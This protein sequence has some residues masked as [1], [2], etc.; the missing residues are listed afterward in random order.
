MKKK[1]VAYIISIVVLASFTA[2]FGSKEAV[3]NSSS[4]REII[5]YN[6]N[7]NEQ[8]NLLLAE[9]IRFFKEKLPKLHKNP[10][11]Y[12]SKKK[13]NERTDQ[14]IENIDSM[15]NNQVLTELNKIIASI[16]DAHTTINIWDGYSYPLQFWLFDGNVYVI[17]ADT[18]LK[19]MMFLTGVKN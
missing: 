7:T 11:S 1:I 5:L 9:D 12:I 3:A 8:R 10:F 19:E 4:N 15:S 17:N 2:C 14:L 16:G 13:F 18:S 6:D